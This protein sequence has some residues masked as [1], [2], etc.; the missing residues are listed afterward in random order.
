MAYSYS[1]L[2]TYQNCPRQYYETK[3]L[4]KWPFPETD[5]IRYGKEVHKA[6]EDYVGGVMP[7]LGPHQRYKNL[8]DSIK[9]IPGEHLLE[10][11]M[12]LDSELNAC[13]FDSEDAFIRGIA[14][15]IVIDRDK[16]RAFIGDYKTG[17]AKYPDVAQLELMALMV[18]RHFPEVKHVKAALLF[19]VHDTIV[20]AEYHK[21]EAKTKWVQWLNKIQAIEQS[22]D[23]GVWNENPSGLCPYCVVNDCPHWREKKNYGR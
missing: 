10:Y 4:K 11:E 8:A 6:L 21:K 19:I 7:D 1:G 15:F 22:H 18:F 13:A 5:A 20:P 12:G 14:D 23:T 17:S 2:K 3:V 9:K 16:N